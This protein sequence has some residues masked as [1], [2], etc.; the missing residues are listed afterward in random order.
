MIRLARAAHRIRVPVYI[1]SMVVII[2]TTLLALSAEDGPVRTTLLTASRVG[3]A[4]FVLAVLVMAL[5]GRLVPRPEPLTVLSPVTG[6]WSALNSPATKVPSHGLHAYGQTWAIDLVHE[7]EDGCRPEFGQGP[8]MRPPA[9]Y[10]AF[11][12]PVLAMVGGEVV[13]ASDGQ[14]DHRSRSSL[15]AAVYLTLEAM[16]RELGG[17]RFIVGNHVTIRT[18]EGT[19]AL[20]AHLQQ[21]S[22]RVAVGDTVVAGQQIGA[23]G[24]SG[25]TSEPHVHAQLMDRRSLLLA[26]GLPM[27]FSHIAVEGEGSDRT[28][29]GLPADEEYMVVTPSDLDAAPET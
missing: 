10:P 4:C 23:C 8:A 29:D 11:G 25:N 26:R 15:G 19:Y 12:E 20:V 3:I 14:R 6:R 5:G 24:N 1:V 7:P 16:V 13:A 28:V 27:A 22:A 9:D 2:T 21:G 17:P 18:D